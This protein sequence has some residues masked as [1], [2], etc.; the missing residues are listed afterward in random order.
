MPGAV[1]WN[2]QFGI[3]QP[4]NL[5][6]AII[7]GRPINRSQDKKGF[8]PSKDLVDKVHKEYVE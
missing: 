5:D 3:V 7:K 8:E 2:R 4:T 6:I 1:F